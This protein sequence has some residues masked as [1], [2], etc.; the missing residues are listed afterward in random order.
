MTLPAKDGVRQAG[1]S[2]M[3]D[4]PAPQ[5]LL[6][7]LEADMALLRKQIKALASE[8]ETFKDVAVLK[9]FLKTWHA[10]ARPPY[11]DNYWF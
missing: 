5:A 11:E 6:R 10:P 7:F 3:V 1:G 9:V 4:M 2:G 8:L